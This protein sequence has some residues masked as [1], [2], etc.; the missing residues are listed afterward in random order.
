[1]TRAT[2]TKVCTKC[3][4]AKPLDEFTF[5]DK[6]HTRRRSQC[7][8]CERDYKQQRRKGPDDVN[9]RSEYF[10]R[11]YAEHKEELSEKASERWRRKHAKAKQTIPCEIV[12]EKYPCFE[13]IETIKTINPFKCHDMKRKEQDNE[14]T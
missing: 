6:A 5:R 10:K 7:K 13:G 3:G 1:M 11:Y 12:C 14:G 2:V 4:K 9:E 8:Q